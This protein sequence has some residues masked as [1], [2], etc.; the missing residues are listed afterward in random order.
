MVLRFEDRGE[1]SALRLAVKLGK[2]AG[3][4]F[5][6]PFEKLN[7]IGPLSPLKKYGGKI[8]EKGDVVGGNFQCF[9]IIGNGPVRLP[10]LEQCETKIAI[11]FGYVGIDLQYLPKMDNGFVRSSGL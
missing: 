7:R 3:K 6:G 11:S 1:G 5:K 4:D 10:G 9:P 2:T 8:V